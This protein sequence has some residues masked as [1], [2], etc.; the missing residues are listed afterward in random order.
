MLRGGGGGVE[1]RGLRLWP[2]I[3]DSVTGRG[4]SPPAC[5]SPPQHQTC[6][7]YVDLWRWP[8]STFNWVRPGPSKDLSPG[9]IK[10]G[11][12]GRH[13][14]NKG[15]SEGQTRSHATSQAQ[16]RRKINH[17]VH[18]STV[19]KCN[20]DILY[21]KVFPFWET[22]LLL[23]SIW[24]GNT[25]IFTPVVTLHV[26]VLHSAFFLSFSLSLVASNEYK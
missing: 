15:N 6:R 18:L 21:V 25:A 2:R 23:C 26:Q 11:G 4:E 22:V 3:D 14:P 8:G 1:R 20:S 24:E 16:Q 12:G 13:L 7:I 17:C 19:L 10:G 9:K 5:H